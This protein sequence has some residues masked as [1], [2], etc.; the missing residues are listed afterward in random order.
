MDEPSGAPTPS[1]PSA[2]AADIL[3]RS[4]IRAI[5][6]LPRGAMVT[7]RAGDLYEL[8]YAPQPRDFTLTIRGDGTFELA[9]VGGVRSGE[10]GAAAL[11]ASELTIAEAAQRI[12]RSRQAVTTAV[13]RGSIV[14]RRLGKKIYLVDIASLDAYAARVRKRKARPPA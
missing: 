13:Q 11:H 7:V 12:G 1:A 5:S 9:I 10:Q 2:T 8:M 14:G 6:A 3:R 4:V